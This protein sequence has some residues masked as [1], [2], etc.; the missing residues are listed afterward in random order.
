MAG[1][2]R[3]ILALCLVTSYVFT[4]FPA[5]ATETISYAYDPGGQLVKVDRN[6]G[7]S[8]CSTSDYAYDKAYNRS[9]VTVAIG[10]CG[11]PSFAVSDTSTTEGL[12]LQFTVTKTG[13]ASSSFSINYAT[14]NGSAT[15]GSDYTAASG[16]LT[17]LSNETSKTVNVTTTDDSSVESTETVTLTLSGAT[18]GA[19]ISDATG[20][21]TIDDNE[22]SFS[23]NDAYAI[24][25]GLLQ[26]VVTRSGST[27]G[28]NQVTVSTA[29]GTAA[30]GTDFSAF[31]G[32]LTFAP[33]ETTKAVNV[34][35]VDNLIFEAT[36]TMTLNLS[37]PTGGATISDSQGVGTIDDN[38]EEE[39]SC[40]PQ[41]CP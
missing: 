28:T 26:F 12:P 18:G 38:D 40:P 6:I 16:T 19:T 5:A 29:S 13:A 15:A 31:T 22:A 27:A 36:E 35:T 25:G 21:G 11:A 24:E 4:V 3:S 41:G 10:T 39:E 8:A 1:R 14:S 9:S 32:T 2:R 20:A 17:F 37:A 7:N 23:V 30:S 34:A 33:N